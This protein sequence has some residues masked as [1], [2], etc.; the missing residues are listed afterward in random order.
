MDNIC[1][2]C[3]DIILFYYLVPVHHRSIIRFSGFL[4]ARCWEHSRYEAFILIDAFFFFFFFHFSFCSLLVFF[5]F[6]FFFFF[7]HF[8]FCSLLVC[9]M[10]YSCSR[11]NFFCTQWFFCSFM[12]LVGWVARFATMSFSF[13]SPFFIFPYF[14]DK[15]SAICSTVSLSSL[16]LCDSGSVV[17]WLEHKH[18]S[19]FNFSSVV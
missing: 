3:I 10:F 5:L 7:L 9:F 13:I 1:S 16:C 2:F 11:S 4:R 19:Y 14:F 15:N 6:F 18:V 12:Y 8:S 17:L